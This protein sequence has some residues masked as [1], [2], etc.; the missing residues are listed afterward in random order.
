MCRALQ[1]VG[2]AIGE[3]E[4]FQEQTRLYRLSSMEEIRQFCHSVK[5]RDETENISCSSGKVVL[6]PSYNPPQEFK[7]LPED[8][9]F[10]VKI[11][12]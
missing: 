6:A 4:A 7:H 12:S 9:L 8:P 10:L 11:K 1:F 2:T 3:L 5:W